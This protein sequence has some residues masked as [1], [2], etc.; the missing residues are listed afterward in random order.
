[1]NAESILNELR[2][3]YGLA[4]IP[5]SFNSSHMF[6]VVGEANDDLL[7]NSSKFKVFRNVDDMVFYSAY[8][9]AKISGN[10]LPDHLHNMMVMDFSGNMHVRLYME[11]VRGQA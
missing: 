2:L 3:L 10:H 6:V 5:F 8:M 7:L 9:F 4:G 1:M 11:A